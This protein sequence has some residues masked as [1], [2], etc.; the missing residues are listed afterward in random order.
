MATRGQKIKA[1]EY[2]KKY[3][4]ELI[5]MR[6]RKNFNQKDIA[7]YLNV[8]LQQYQKYENGINKVSVATENKIAE[9]YGI[10]RLELVKKIEEQMN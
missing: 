3:G 4:Q 7:D 10:T 1:G 8:T 6:I 2:E 5:I 9:F